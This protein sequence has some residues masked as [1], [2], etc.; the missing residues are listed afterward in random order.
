MMKDKRNDFS[1]KWSETLKEW[2]RRKQPD[3]LE[4]PEFVGK[5]FCELENL[6]PSNYIVHDANNGNLEL[7]CE[8]GTITCSIKDGVCTK[9]YFLSNEDG[10]E[11]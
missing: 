11:D 3:A 8:N 6:F 10:D 5:C 7:T 4:L 1:A 9:A 2:I